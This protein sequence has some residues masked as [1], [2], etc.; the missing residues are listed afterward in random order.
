MNPEPATAP[1]PPV[2][3]V[4][5]NWLERHWWKLLIALLLGGIGISVVCCGGI[6]FAIFGSLRSSE[7]VTMTID[8]LA[9]E[10]AVIDHTGEPISA[11]WFVLGSIHWNNDAGSASLSIPIKGP[12]G[13]AEASVEATRQSGRWHI[14]ALTVKLEGSGEVIDLVSP[15]TPPDR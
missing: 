2:P 15:T 5:T 6:V 11:G 3:P 10:P 8:R 12:D 13:T 4:E 1:S 7:V 9:A 14:D